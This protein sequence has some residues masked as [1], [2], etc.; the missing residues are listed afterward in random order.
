[1]F[2]TLHDL[3][4]V[5][6]WEDLEHL[7]SHVLLGTGLLTSPEMAVTLVILPCL[8][9]VLEVP[10]SGPTG[11]LG[12][13]SGQRSDRA[14]ER[15]YRTFWE[16][17][18]DSFQGIR[19]GLSGSLGSGRYRGIIVS[20]GGSVHQPSTVQEPRVGRISML[21]HMLQPFRFQSYFVYC[22]A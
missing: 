16:V 15:Y 6:S 11:P 3:P 19:E 10:S 7:K 22:I 2:P 21:P 5:W 13:T 20:T 8:S 1:M 17:L 12:G 4:W 18:L 9:L 14:L